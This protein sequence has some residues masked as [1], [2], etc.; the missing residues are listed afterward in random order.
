MAVDA[1][2]TRELEC[3]R[4]SATSAARVHASVDVCGDRRDQGP[5]RQPTHDAV[6]AGEWK[7]GGFYICKSETYLCSQYAPARRRREQYQQ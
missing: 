2:A 3:G 4:P 5:A 6:S 7:V 1:A